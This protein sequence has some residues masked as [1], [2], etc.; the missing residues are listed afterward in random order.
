MSA[1]SEVEESNSMS[2]SMSI[3]DV[4]E[5]LVMRT[6]VPFVDLSEN[7]VLRPPGPPGP[8]VDLSGCNESD[9]NTIAPYM[10][11][12]DEFARVIDTYSVLVQH[13]VVS[14]ADT[15]D[16]F[17]FT[18]NSKMCYGT[19]NTGS[20]SLLAI[21]FRTRDT[22]LVSLNNVVV[23]LNMFLQTIKCSSQNP[24]TDDVTL[25]PARTELRAPVTVLTQSV[26]CTT[27]VSGENTITIPRTSV[28]V[29]IQAL[30]TLTKFANQTV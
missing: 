3:V 27:R 5:N 6:P 20:G 4:S 17:L 13:K 23:P 26:T 30:Q 24:Q 25:P 16:Y 14:N 28:P 19:P 11:S 10:F 8:F 21:V 12:N 22:Q 1:V 18:P 2:M 15:R 29:V 9:D 7:L